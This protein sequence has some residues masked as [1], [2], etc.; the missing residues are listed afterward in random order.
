M[1]GRRSKRDRTLDPVDTERGFS[2]PDHLKPYV[3]IAELS[4]LTPW[5]ENAIRTMMSRGI[6]RE[7]YHYFHVRRRAVF[8][9]VNLVEFIQ[10]GDWPDGPA[11]ADAPVPHYRDRQ[12]AWEDDEESDDKPARSK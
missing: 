12:E 3:S 1:A 8:K 2:E 11:E 4:R 10:K 5:S 6:F 7:G 9:W